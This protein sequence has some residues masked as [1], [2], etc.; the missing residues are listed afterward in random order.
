MWRW[1]G[2]VHEYFARTGHPMEEISLIS[3]DLRSRHPGRQNPYRGVAGVTEW[4]ADFAAAW[5]HYEMESS[6]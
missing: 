4:L 3:R 5:D 1:S 2:A 6:A